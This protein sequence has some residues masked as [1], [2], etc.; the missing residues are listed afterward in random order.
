[1]D[2]VELRFHIL[3]N[4][5]NLDCAVAIDIDSKKRRNEIGIGLVYQFIIILQRPETTKKKN[6]LEYIFSH[7]KKFKYQKEREQVPPF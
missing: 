1:M 7:N 5:N 4:N 2:V 6:S 3:N